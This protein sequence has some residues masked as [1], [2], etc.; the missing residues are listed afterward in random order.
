MRDERN[1][2]LYIHIPFCAKKCLYCDFLSFPAPVKTYFE[3]VN[4][5]TEEIR[6]QGAGFA[7]RKVV[8][9]F[10]GGG[11]PSILSPQMMIDIFRA[12]YQSFEVEEN[13]E[14][15]IEANP[16][17]LTPD[18]L[19]AYRACGINR[20]SL[21]LQSADDNE[22][23]QLGRIHSYDEFLK[24]Y[25]AARMAGFTNINVDLMSA[26]PGQT[27]QSWKNTLKKVLMLR[28]EH[29]SAYSLIIEEGT[30]FYDHYGENGVCKTAIEA[31]Q[32]KA[33]ELC[34]EPK[35][36]KEELDYV[37][38]GSSRGMASAAG[39]GTTAR[40]VSGNAAAATESRKQEEDNVKPKLTWPALPDEDTDR[41]MYHITKEM[42]ETHGYLRYEIS[43]YAKPGSECRHNEGY[44][45]GVDY[46]GLGLGASSCVSG[47]RY[48]N[49]QDFAEY[50]EL[51]LTQP[52][53]A[54]REIEELTKKDKMEEFMFLGLR[55]T[56]GV[57]GSDFMERFG[58]NMWK[59]YG[60]VI[61]KLEKQGLLEV[62]TPDIRLTELGLDVSNQ[63]FCEFLLDE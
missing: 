17:T 54:A 34:G 19:E 24:S 2:E 48:H 4:K 30:A 5:L 38:I 33:D 40:S 52:G 29:I 8:S 13:C 6:A 28:P 42:M 22:L 50:M 3:Y 53:A 25:Q 27:V 26:L 61:G 12:I 20:I 60:N 41:E 39:A 56:G 14:I 11:T 9:I 36:E 59:V 37:A 63:V 35:R 32:K 16:G 1:L 44:W 7:G 57:S 23:R 58:E 55:M 43:N 10:L 45:T 46:L 15:T 31:L 62:R 18:R 49:T 21:G 51:D 47:F